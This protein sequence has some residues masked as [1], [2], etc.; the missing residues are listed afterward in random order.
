MDRDAVMSA[1]RDRLASVS[2]GDEDTRARRTELLEQ[3]FPEALH[4]IVDA[5]GVFADVN[6]LHVRSAHVQ[7]EPQTP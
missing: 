5:G 6:A 7:V 4:S 2:F 3:D 1:V